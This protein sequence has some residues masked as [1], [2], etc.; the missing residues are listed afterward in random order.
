MINYQI[1]SITI[2]YNN[3]QKNNLKN[4]LYLNNHYLLLSIISINKCHLIIV[5]III[6][7]HNLI[8]IIILWPLKIITNVNLLSI[9]LKH[10]NLNLYLNNNHYK[11]YLHSLI[12]SHNLSLIKSHN[13]ILT[14]INKL[15]LIKILINLNKLILDLNNLINKIINQYKPQN[16][17][18]NRLQLFKKIKIHY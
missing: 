12:K 5:I 9:I 3:I 10:Q 8:I 16:K 7:K 13:L 4:Y 14:I 18:N 15:T 17:L 11:I 1:T 6:T 2:I